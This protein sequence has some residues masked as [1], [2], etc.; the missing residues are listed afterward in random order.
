[1]GI[2]YFLEEQYWERMEISTQ[3]AIAKAFDG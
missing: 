2:A 1:M 3:N